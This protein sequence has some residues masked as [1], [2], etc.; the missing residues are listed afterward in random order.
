MPK[1][2]ELKKAYKTDFAAVN[3][4]TNAEVERNA[5]VDM[6]NPATSASHWA[7]GFVGLPPLK[8]PVAAKFDADVVEWFKSQGRGYQ[9]RMNAVLR[10]Y[11]EAHRKAG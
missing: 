10:R 4:M 2:R 3:A 8:T 6:E 11:M 7:E 9:T 1:S 5:Q